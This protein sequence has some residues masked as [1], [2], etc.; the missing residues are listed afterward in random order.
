MLL[1]SIF[2][3]SAEYAFEG[4]MRFMARIDKRSI[5]LSNNRLRFYGLVHDA[6]LFLGD[7]EI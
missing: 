7:T 3:Y 5:V 2:L 4:E 6:G 1:K